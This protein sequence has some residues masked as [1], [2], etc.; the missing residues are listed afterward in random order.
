M[1]S[2]L[3]LFNKVSNE[4][5]TI[6]KSIQYLNDS[7][8]T[9]NQRIMYGND[10]LAWFQFYNNV[11]FLLYLFFL[12]IFLIVL[13]LKKN[14]LRSTKLFLFLTFSLFPFIITSIELF[15]YNIIIYIYTFLFLRMYPGNAF[16]K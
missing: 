10:Q 1:V 5:K 16:Y 8:S 3:D 4:N 15:F 12:L 13:F 14:Y 6:N 11:L 2:Y 9:D 7:S